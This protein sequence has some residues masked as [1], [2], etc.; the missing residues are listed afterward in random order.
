MTHCAHKENLGGDNQPFIWSCKKG[1]VWVGKDC[2]KTCMYKD[3]KGEMRVR[4]MLKPAKQKDKY[5]IALSKKQIKRTLELF[6]E[7]GDGISDIDKK[8]EKK[9]RGAL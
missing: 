9:L 2:E 5:I 8:I 4:D 6:H 1:W 3:V 7:W